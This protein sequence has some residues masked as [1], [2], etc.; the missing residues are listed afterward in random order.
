MSQNW[1]H[2]N[3]LHQIDEKF[4]GLRRALARTLLDE[5]KIDLLY[6]ELGDLIDEAK[7]VRRR[8]AGNDVPRDE[9]GGLPPYRGGEPPAREISD[10]KQLMGMGERLG[11]DLIRL[12][13]TANYAQAKSE[14]LRVYRAIDR[15][16]RRRNRNAKEVN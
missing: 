5:N 16:A 10:P 8:R 14:C 1:E 12:I 2:L 3:I 7:R 9:S 13:D 15:F 11:S 6:I 4:M